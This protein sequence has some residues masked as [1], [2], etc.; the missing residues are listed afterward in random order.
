MSEGNQTLRPSF[1]AVLA[2]DVLLSSAFGVVLTIAAGPIFEALELDWPW[3]WQ[4]ATVAGGLSFLLLLGW[5]R[6]SATGHRLANRIEAFYEAAQL[7]R[8]FQLQ[9]D[10]LNMRET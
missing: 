8:A 4:V 2:H 3:Y 1:W 6:D 5:L 10:K 7:D 9:N